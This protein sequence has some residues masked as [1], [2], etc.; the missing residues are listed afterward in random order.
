[1]TLD[2]QLIT[3]GAMIVGGMYLGMANDTFRRFTPLWKKSRVLTYILEILFWLTQI[4]VL[5]YVLYRINFGE[6][7]IYYFVAIAFGFTLYITFLQTI[8]KKLL[9]LFIRFVTKLLTILYNIVVTPIIYIVKLIIRILLWIIR[10]ILKLLYAIV[11]LLHAIIK[12]ILPEKVYKFI[13]KKVVTYSTMIVT[14]YKKLFSRIR[15]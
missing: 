11:K 8:Y 7:R 9:H 15:K 4:T 10:I 13:S 3:M 6:I 12:L 2:T 5:F 14:L 1:M